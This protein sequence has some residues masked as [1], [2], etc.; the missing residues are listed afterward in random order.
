MVGNSILHLTIRFAHM[1]F[2]SPES[3]CTCTDLQVQH[4]YEIMHEKMR[5]TILERDKKEDTTERTTPTH[6]IRIISQPMVALTPSDRSALFSAAVSAPYIPDA[7]VA[8]ASPAN[9]DT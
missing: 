6:M 2:Q 9:D 1:R 4:V 7:D 3:C 5:A 8:A